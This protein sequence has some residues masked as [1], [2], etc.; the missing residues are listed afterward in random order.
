M[1]RR[2][3][4]VRQALRERFVVT[5]KGGETFEGLLL[6]ADEKTVKLTDAYAL[7]GSSRI[8]VDGSLYLP[9]PEVSYLQKPPG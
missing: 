6:D 1:S 2:D 7:Q 4:L 8:Q 3:R 9:R 5:L